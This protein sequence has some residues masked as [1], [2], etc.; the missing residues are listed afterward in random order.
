MNTKN[1]ARIKTSFVVFLLRLGI[2]KYLT[3]TKAARTKSISSLSFTNAE[4]QEY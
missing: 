3:T 4:I 1:K 2:D